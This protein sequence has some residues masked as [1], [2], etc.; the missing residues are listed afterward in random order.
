MY[1][2]S[3][4]IQ[5]GTICA[6]VAAGQSYSW[7]D[8]STQQ[9]YIYPGGIA[10][11]A[12]LIVYR[13]ADGSESFHNSAILQALQHIHNNL[14]NTFVDVV[15]MSFD[16]KGGSAGDVVNLHKIIEDL[17]RSGVILV[18]AAGNNGMNQARAKMPASIQN[19]ISVGALDRYGYK[20]CLSPPSGLID[21]FVPGEDIPVPLSSEVVQGTSFATAAVAGLVSLMVQCVKQSFPGNLALIKRL[22]EPEVLKRIFNHHMIKCIPQQ[23]GKT[24]DRVLDPCGFFEHINEDKTWL[25]T[26]LLEQPSSVDGLKDQQMPVSDNIVVKIIGNYSTENIVF[27]HHNKLLYILIEHL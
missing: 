4:S 1:I 5:H 27:S 8:S 9:T 20:S 2:P 13:V 23:D 22:S 3:V 21:V 10:P 12:D 26:I 24:V 14:Q 19:V 17:S 18:A 15:S 7:I 6:A 25:E 16:F 11:E